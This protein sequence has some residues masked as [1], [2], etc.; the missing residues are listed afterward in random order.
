M[1]A[2]KTATTKAKTPAA[3]N[4][5]STSA[6]NGDGATATRSR[7][8]NRDLVIVESPA[9]ART[10]SGILGSRYEVTASVGH[11]RDLPKSK[12]GVDVENDF[13]PHYIVPKE[14]KDVIQ[15]IKDAASKASTIYLATDPDREGEAISW[16]LVEAAGLDQAPNRQLHRVV[17]HEL[18]PGAILEAFDHPRD[19]DYALVD[20]QQARRVLDRLVGYKIS[21]LL[22]RKVRRGL[23]AGR[24]QSAALRMIV[25]R[26]REILDFT[27]REYWSI[28][29]LLAQIGVANAV[30]FSAR[31]RGKQGQRTF[32]LPSDEATQH[33]TEQLR[34]A[35]F[36]VRSVKRRDQHRRPA[37][38]F[39]TSTLQQEASRRF[40]YTARRTMALAQQLYEGID[41]RGA[42]RAGLITY[43]RTDSTNLAEVAVEEIRGFVGQRFGRDYVPAAPRAY[44]SRKGAQEAHEAI[45]PTSVL[46]EPNSPELRALTPD[47]RRLYTLI[48][49]RA[50]ACQMADAILDSV[51]VDIDATA[52]DGDVYHLRASASA[53]RFPGYRALYEEAKDTTG[54]EEEQQQLATPLPEMN[55]GDRLELHD[56][57]PEQHFTEPPPRYTEATLVKALEENGIGRPSTY[58]PILGTIQ[59]RG[60]VER[61]QR[62]LR[63]TELGMLVND[64]LRDYFPNVVDLGFTAEMEEDLDEVASGLRPWQPMV[65]EFY[66]PLEKALEGADDA[67][68]AEVEIGELCPECERPLIRKYGRFGQF[69]ACSGFPECRYTRQD[70]ETGEPQTTDELCDTCGSAMVVK[71]GRFGAFLA[72]TK[73]PECKGTKPLLQKTGVLCPKDGGEVVERMTRQKRKFF[74]CANYPACDFTS[75]Q[76]P[77]P[78]RCPV[79]SGLLVALRNRA[80]CT[81]CGWQGSPDEAIDIDS[82]VA[83]TPPPKR[84]ESDAEDGATKAST[85][86][87]PRGRAKAKS[88]GTKKAST[89]SPAR[90][91]RTATAA[92]AAGEDT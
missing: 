37:P 90:R 55:E 62:Q 5:R 87:T 65:R 53:V 11:V 45:R 77:L 64:F 43:M 17:F 92:A 78:G 44:R 57:K 52:T 24:V 75:W 83:G 60:Y 1:P 51:S 81:I 49:Q 80:R 61:E 25:D 66:N 20:A 2:K 68:K 12:L 30:E 86:K 10:I 18:T 16:H 27:A 22:W 71:R 82:R 88:T 91:T 85:A 29:A 89:R 84:E 73:Y 13:A 70:G 14:K 46:R 19:I 79:D 26:E 28:E 3:R 74:G 72:C 58:A 67:P 8:G 54:D 35:T 15:R 50:V 48:W 40:G 23:S 38:P 36:N 6:A 39:T 33:V 9:K 7:R 34:S 59:E 76:K 4:G 63:P 69:I 21:P 47:Q 31:L 56:L 42:G 41:L 32:E